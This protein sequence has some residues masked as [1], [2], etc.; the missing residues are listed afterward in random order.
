MYLFVSSMAASPWTRLRS[1]KSIASNAASPAHSPTARTRTPAHS[2]ARTPTARPRTPA[3][4]P[5]RAQKQKKQ[6]LWKAVLGLLQRQSSPPQKR[7]TKPL[8][9]RNNGL[10]VPTRYAPRFAEASP[11]RR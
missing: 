3:R 2:P 4:T 11:N 7:S 9:Y 5:S 10:G 8:N 1:L 6:V